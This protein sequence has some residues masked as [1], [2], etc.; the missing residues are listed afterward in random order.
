MASDKLL[1]LIEYIGADYHNAV[2][3]KGTIASVVEYQE[4]LEFAALI[5]QEGEFYDNEE[6]NQQ[7]LT[8]EKLV[9]Q[10]SNP[11]QV[12]QLTSQ[13][14]IKMLK[15]M[16]HFS[17]PADIPSRSHG[18]VLYTHHCMACHGATGKG[19]G[20]NASFLAPK[21]TNFT[22]A[23]RYK[24]RSM[25]GL[26]NTISIGVSGT[27][28][29]SF[30]HFT[31]QDRWDLAFYVGALAGRPSV[32]PIPQHLLN[33]TQLKLF[34][35]AT[36]ADMRT[37]FGDIGFDAM[38]AFR[39]KPELG[40]RQSQFTPWQIS[41]NYLQQIK[42]QGNDHKAAYGLAI[43][44][45][46]EGF[47]LVERQ[48]E[49]VDHTKRNLIEK[50]MLELRTKIAKSTSGQY[51]ELAQDIDNLIAELIEAE[52]ILNNT[53]LSAWSV[54][55]FSLLILLREGLEALLVVAA[56]AAVARKTEN[57]QL[58]ISV[59]TGGL[60][61]LLLGLFTWY[62]ASYVIDIS[63]ASRELTEGMTALFAAIILFY[64]GFWMHSNT[65]AQQWQKFIKNKVSTALSER[66]YWA[67]GI[68]VFLAVYREVFETILF[69][70]SLWLQGGDQAEKAFFLGLVAGILLLILGGSL[71]FKWSVSLPIKP[72]FGGSAIFML[73][74]AIIMAGKGMAA[75]HEAG[76][77]TSAQ[78]GFESISWLGL[79]P[80]WQG[81]VLQIGLI[82]LSAV[83]ILKN[84]RK[85]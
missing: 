14:R 4:M 26:Y 41:R 74:L 54:F 29:K 8:L 11:I 30:A 46:L 80:I 23:A 49:T 25:L 3:V 50:Q 37:K 68:V 10:K 6:F 22:H 78:L 7:A 73:I 5:R 85:V 69:Y 84:N 40:F 52:Q 67:L 28:M 62:M 81:V 36:P 47:E 70:Q 33:H 58:M 66:T 61:A 34:L 77:F 55:V 20:A 59:H 31:E 57:S 32:D 13:L 63:G 1:Q 24:T 72:F 42:K 60:L 44:A 18:E 76:I 16:P 43:A 17:F 48:L 83:Y 51:I 71:L 53:Q 35:T 15:V 39:L 9:Q 27:A 56:I 64:M 12:Q 45:Y 19:D 79:F 65:H 38:A 75:L 82:L 2:T 21:P